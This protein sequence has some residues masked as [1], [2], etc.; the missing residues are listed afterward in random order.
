MNMPSTN[1]AG[2]RPP[3]DEASAT[4]VASPSKSPS[5]AWNSILI[6]ELEYRARQ[7]RSTKGTN[8]D[9]EN[10]GLTGRS[11]LEGAALLRQPDSKDVKVSR[12][13]AV[14]GLPFEK[15]SSVWSLTRDI[16]RGEVELTCPGLSVLASSTLAPGANPAHVQLEIG[17][18]GASPKKVKD[19]P[20]ASS[21]QKKTT[22]ATSRKKYLDH[23]PREETCVRKCFCWRVCVE[24][25]QL[26]KATIANTPKFVPNVKRCRCVDVYD[27]DTITVVAKT[28]MCNSP[29]LF[30][31]RLAR[32]DTPEMRGSGV[33]PAEKKLAIAARDALSEKI[34][35]RIIRLEN[36]QLEKYGRL[37]AEVVCLRTGEN[38]NDWLLET[39]H[40]KLYDGGTKDR[41]W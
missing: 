21:T 36:V 32:I 22:T 7:L 25:P 29:Q 12:S 10:D 8:D 30:K 19:N 9:D 11:L 33:T 17:G 38:L 1:V 6:A 24:D 15:G 5:P 27:G 28:S 39:G 40:A 3:H 31:V 20:L 37:L 18:A 2:G 4:D 16:V 23:I 34:L 35:D 14:L 41:E 26:R 13:G